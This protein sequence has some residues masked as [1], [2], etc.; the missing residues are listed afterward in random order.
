MERRFVGPGEI[1]VGVERRRVGFG[2]C[3]LERLRLR[4]HVDDDGRGCF[5]H[6]G[7]RFRR[8]LFLDLRRGRKPTPYPDR[9]DSQLFDQHFIE[10]HA[11]S[12]P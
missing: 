10:R 3:G 12:P 6:R 11:Q 9:P 8:A 5:R 2:L 1:V 4:P 7:D